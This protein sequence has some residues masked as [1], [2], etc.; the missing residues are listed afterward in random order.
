MR[1]KRLQETIAKRTLRGMELLS[2]TDAYGVEVGLL[3]AGERYTLLVAIRDPRSSASTTRFTARVEAWSLW[4]QSLGLDD[5][6]TGASLSVQTWESGAS[7]AVVGLSFTARPRPGLDRKPLRRAEMV[8]EV[9]THLARVLDGL[10]AT[11]EGLEV[12]VC[13][14]QDIVDLVR[15]AFDSSIAQDVEAARAGE[16]TGLTWVDAPPRPEATAASFYSHDRV[17]STSWTMAARADEALPPLDFDTALVPTQGVVCKRATLI[18]RIAPTLEAK[19]APFGLVVTADVR[20]TETVPLAQQLPARQALRTR[21]R[22]R[23]ATSAQDTTFL[24]GLPL[25][26]ATPHLVMVPRELKETA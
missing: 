10:R 2:Q 14:A 9:S 25:D 11:A 20:G 17:V 5:R 3:A 18:H 6:V 8:E 22:L 21:L 19:L 23:A 26:L 13:T 4:L 7:S 12:R 16:G 15:V 24:A 1:T